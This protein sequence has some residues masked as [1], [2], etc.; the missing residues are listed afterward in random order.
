[1][2]QLILAEANFLSTIDKISIT[3]DKSGALSNKFLA[4]VDK[5]GAATDK[6]LALTDKSGAATDKPTAL[7]DKSGAIVKSTAPTE[8][9]DLSTDKPL[10]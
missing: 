8:N 10:Q 9:L 7:T 4:M 2:G 5:S 1:M 6:L 3:T